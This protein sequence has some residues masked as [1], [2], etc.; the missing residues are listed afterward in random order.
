MGLMLRKW[1]D[2]ANEPVIRR[3]ELVYLYDDGTWTAA[4]G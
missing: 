1:Q 4:L 3:C 2:P